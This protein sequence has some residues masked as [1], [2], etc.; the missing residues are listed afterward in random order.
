M[1]DERRRR[2][3]DVLHDP[4]QSVRLAAA[5][6]LERLETLSE[7]E[8]LIAA[9]KGADRGKR[10]QAIYALERIRSDEVYPALHE[11]LEDPDADIRAASS[12]GCSDGREAFNR[13][14]PARKLAVDASA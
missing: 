9:V 14:P 13:A 8:Q 3:M 5:T 12:G 7:L 6:A 4:D 1:L 11:A 10:V 2:L